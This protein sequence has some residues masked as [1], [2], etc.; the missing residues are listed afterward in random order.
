MLTVV[1]LAK[2]TAKMTISNAV[3]LKSYRGRKIT[4]GF[5]KKIKD[6]LQGLSSFSRLPHSYLIK[7]TSLE[8]ISF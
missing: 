5:M 4:S 1:Q 3:L 2:E 6:Y 7:L 8:V